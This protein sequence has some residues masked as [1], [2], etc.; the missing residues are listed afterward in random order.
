MSQPTAQRFDVFNGTDDA[1]LMQIMERSR[2]TG[3]ASKLKT[4]AAVTR[5]YLTVLS[6][7]PISLDSTASPTLLT[8][9]TTG[10]FTI[11]LGG[12]SIPEGTYGFR[13]IIVEGGSDKQLVHEDVHDAKI[14]VVDTTLPS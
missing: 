3:S 12:E 9:N 8:W 1:I 14:K 6:P 10:K 4:P 11:I 7:T 13:L 2:E 5:A